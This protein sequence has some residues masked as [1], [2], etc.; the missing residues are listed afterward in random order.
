M[1]RCLFLVVLLPAWLIIARPVGADCYDRSC[2]QAP[3]TGYLESHG[4]TPAAE[5]TDVSLSIYIAP[6]QLM[7]LLPDRQNNL[8]QTINLSDGRQLQADIGSNS[9]PLRM[10]LVDNRLR[11]VSQPA[12]WPL[13]DSEQV[14]FVFLKN[15]ERQTP[16][17]AVQPQ[18]YA[19]R[20]FGGY[21]INF[22]YFYQLSS[23][24]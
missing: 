19:M 18:I 7:P 4:F 8:I 16:W 22:A 6:Y 5:I 14:L 10:S 2:P 12:S 1:R 3:A 24:P 15:K 20:V 13:P 11:S 9:Y 21:G 23:L 17:S